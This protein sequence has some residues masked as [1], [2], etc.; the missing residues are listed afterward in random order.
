MARLAAGSLVLLALVGLCAARLP[1]VF[2][3]AS[4]RL[5]QDM[6]ATG[7]PP[8]VPRVVQAQNASLRS[9]KSSFVFA[10]LSSLTTQMAI[11]FHRGALCPVV[12]AQA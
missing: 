6:N 8:W 5:L 2:P 3:H 9:G 11:A 7:F 1:P 4:R 12:V 10:S